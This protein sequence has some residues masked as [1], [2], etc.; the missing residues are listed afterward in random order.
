[1]VY[2]YKSHEEIPS[3]MRDYLLGIADVNHVEELDLDEINDF[4]N[5]QEEWHDEQGNIPDSLR[6]VH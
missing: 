4:L 6:S 2:K 3:Y 5:G 1:M